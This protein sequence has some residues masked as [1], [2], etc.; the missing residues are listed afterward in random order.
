VRAK[1]EAGGRVVEVDCADV[2]VTPSDLLA[3]ALKTWQATE[4]APD[5]RGPAYGFSQDRRGCQ[6]SPM[7]Y[8][9]GPGR[10]DR[11]DPQAEVQT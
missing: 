4:G 5:S 8:G 1:I 9:A 2:N 7:N 11:G 6:V 10:I 3:E